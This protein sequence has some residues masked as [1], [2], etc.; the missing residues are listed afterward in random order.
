MQVVNYIKK[1]FCSHCICAALTYNETQRYTVALS[2]WKER[3]NI[4]SHEIQKDR[5]GCKQAICQ[6]FM[7][8]KPEEL[9][10]SPKRQG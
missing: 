5:V 8:H 3:P 7:Y 6:R 4:A 10:N 1:G 9:S 2:L